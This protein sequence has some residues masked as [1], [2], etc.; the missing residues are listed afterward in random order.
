[1]AIKI[2]DD[3]KYGYR[4]AVICEICQREIV[5]AADGTTAF[6]TDEDR[7]LFE[8]SFLHNAR[9][10]KRF[11]NQASITVSDIPLPEFLIYLE[12]NMKLD[13]EHA[14]QIADVLSKTY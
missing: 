12:R 13:R 9:C 2:K 7:G 8:I 10:F 14:E 11:C 1:M 3:P 5:R 6:I 4:P